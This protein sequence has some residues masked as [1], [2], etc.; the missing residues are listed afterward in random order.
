M[1]RKH[2]DSYIQAYINNYYYYF[3]PGLLLF[4]TYYYQDSANCMREL[5]E[6]MKPLGSDFHHPAPLYNAADHYETLRE[7]LM[8]VP[9]IVLLMYAPTYIWFL[10]LLLLYGIHKKMPKALS[11][12]AV[13][14]IVVCVCLVGPCNGY[15]FRYLYPIV[16]V[17]PM[18]IPLY[19]SMRHVV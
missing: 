10:L 13:P 14:V 6:A 7:T 4:N 19:F 9:L 15:H 11:L 3:Y 5:N 1:F 16:F 2:P 12:L 17:F 8:Y 18:L